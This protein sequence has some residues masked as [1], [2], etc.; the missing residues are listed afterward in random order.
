MRRFWDFF[1]FYSWTLVSHL[2]SHA[3]HFFLPSHT[4]VTYTSILFPSCVPYV[5]GSRETNAINSCVRVGHA[6]EHTHA[7]QEKYPS[8]ATLRYIRTAQAA[9]LVPNV[10]QA[11]AE[12]GRRV[13]DA[14][15]LL[16]QGERGAGEVAARLSSHLDTFTGMYTWENLV[17]HHLLLFCKVEVVNEGSVHLMVSGHSS[18]R[19]FA[20]E[21]ITTGISLEANHRS[22]ATLEDYY[23]SLILK[24]DIIIVLVIFIGILIITF[25]I[26]NVALLWL[27]TILTSTR[28]FIA[29]KAQYISIKL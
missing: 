7:W 13:P 15:G 19:T 17:D 26:T 10:H 20:T 14:A 11:G 18:P 9:V 27:Y 8:N 12:R 1:L 5:R 29:L 28:C 23:G 4:I 6:C 2:V 24:S 25:N 21:F 3:C 22:V 16:H